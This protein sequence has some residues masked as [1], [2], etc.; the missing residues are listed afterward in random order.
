LRI[1]T[2]TVV[3]IEGIHNQRII[4]VRPLLS[5]AQVGAALPI[6]PAQQEVVHAG[7]DD[8]AAILNGNDDRLL[9]IVGPCSVHDPVAAL[10]YAN[11]LSLKA[12]S[13]L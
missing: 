5:P 12:P 10:E 8:V 2:S 9:V 4:E 3:S 13:D 7:R 6:S 11:L 1:G